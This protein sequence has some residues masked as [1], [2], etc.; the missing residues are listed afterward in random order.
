M[1]HTPQYVTVRAI[2]EVVKRHATATG[3]PRHTCS[4]DLPAP[5]QV[6]V[7]R[8]MDS[9]SLSRTLRAEGNGHLLAG[10]PLDAIVSYT[11]ALAI[12][13]T[14]RAALLS[15]RSAAHLEA[16]DAAAAEAD[17][18]AC[19]AADAS[20]LKGFTRL[21]AALEARGNALEGARALAQGARIAG[22]SAEA[23]P[24]R[25]AADGAIKRYEAESRARDDAALAAGALPTPSLD[26]AVRAAAVPVDVAAALAAAPTLA[27]LAAPHTSIR[28]VSRVSDGARGRGV[29]AARALRAGETVLCDVAAIYYPMLCNDVGGA[30]AGLALRPLWLRGGGGAAGSRAGGGA[31]AGTRDTWPA[32]CADGSPH[33]ALDGVLLQLAPFSSSAGNVGGSARATPARVSRGE[34]YAAVASLNALS[35]V[36]DEDAPA[37]VRRVLFVAPVAAMLNHS[38]GPSCAIE[39]FWDEDSRAPAVRIIAEVDIADGEELTI[40]YVPRSATRAERRT[41]LQGY[42]FSCSCARCA[43]PADDSESFVCSGAPACGGAVSCDTLRCDT[44][45]ATAASAPP[46]EAVARTERAEWLNRAARDVDVLFSPS[47]PLHARDQSLFDLRYASLGPLW[48]DARVTPAFRAA[49]ALAVVDSPALARNGRGSMFALDALHIAAHYSALAGDAKGASKLYARV[50]VLA[51]AAHGDDD[52]RARFAETLAASPP[53]SREGAE[54]AESEKLRATASWVRLH[55]M[56]PRF[57]SYFQTPVK[58]IGDGVTDG[59]ALESLDD[60]FIAATRAWLP[61]R[62]NLHSY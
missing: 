25:A 42:G 44:C 28:V 60:V 58:R 26:A 56:P 18:R 43:A 47:A 46:N 15:N 27:E 35:G 13:T 14:D 1:P 12:A 62:A 29:V 45:G 22:G 50:A 53:T 24:L 17:A 3:A 38:C 39:S 40:S 61:W 57:A 20:F 7:C 16:G 4:H 36:Y 21:A 32:S 5:S 41:R 31:W 11:A 48:A 23:E 30:I 49:A 59:V 9:A 37:D 52:P 51:R 8:R 33:S 54:R 34:L 10:R 55:G 6:T 19:L 2:L